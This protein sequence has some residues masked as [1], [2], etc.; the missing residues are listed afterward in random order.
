MF[1]GK[2][3]LRYRAIFLHKSDRRLPTFVA[4]TAYLTIKRGMLVAQKHVIAIL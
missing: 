1:L 4:A 2:W 3:L